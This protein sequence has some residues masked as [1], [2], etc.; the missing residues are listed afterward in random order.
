MEVGEVT[1]V[2]EAGEDTVGDMV[3][4]EVGEGAMVGG[5]EAGDI[6]V[7]SDVKCKR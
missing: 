6:M 5:E 7:K 1:E 2:T 4:G 3:D